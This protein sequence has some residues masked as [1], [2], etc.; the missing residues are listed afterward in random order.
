MH[1]LGRRP[2]AV[3]AVDHVAVGV[4]DLDGGVGIGAL[5]AIGEDG[6]GG[7]MSSTVTSAAPIGSDTVSASGVVRPIAGRCR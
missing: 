4:E 1:L 2:V 5:A 3:A 6:I 7:G